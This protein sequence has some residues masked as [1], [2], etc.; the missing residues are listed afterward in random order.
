M[1]KVKEPS[2]LGDGVYVKKCESG[3]DTIVLYTFDGL[4]VKDEIFIEPE[5]FQSLMR[6]I[7]AQY[8][9]E[10]RCVVK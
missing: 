4:H 6:W 5:V 9:V 1:S 10:I 2:Y 8:K 7:G 3:E